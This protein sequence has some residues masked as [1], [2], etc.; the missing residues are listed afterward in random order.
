[1]A[2]DQLPAVIERTDDRKTMPALVQDAGGAGWF[3]WEE[4]FWPRSAIRIQGGPTA[5]R[6]GDFSPGAAAASSRSP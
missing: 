1:M 6:Y 4:F 3:V 2:R 5:T